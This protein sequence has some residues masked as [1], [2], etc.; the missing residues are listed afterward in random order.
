MLEATLKDANRYSMVDTWARLETLFTLCSLSSQDTH[1]GRL[2]VSQTPTGCV[3]MIIDWLH[4]RGGWDLLHFSTEGISGRQVDFASEAERNA[5]NP[6]HNAMHR[7]HYNV[8]SVKVLSLTPDATLNNSL[9]Q[10][11]AIS[12][13]QP[14][15]KIENRCNMSRDTRRVG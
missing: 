8:S 5:A 1:H 9:S 3:I 6:M 11:D 12:K 7:Q 15:G 2:L 13:E 10:R 4:M 14:A